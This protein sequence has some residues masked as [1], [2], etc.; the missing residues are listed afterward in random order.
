ME[1]IQSLCNQLVELAEKFNKNTSNFDKAKLIENELNKHKDVL[2]PFYN[3]IVAPM[4][5]MGEIIYDYEDTRRWFMRLEESY[6]AFYFFTF[7]RDME[8]QQDK[9]GRFVDHQYSNVL[10]KSI[11]FDPAHCLEQTISIFTDRLK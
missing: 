8:G 4:I 9:F 10:P 6:G 1:N 11:V 5:C 7:C 2:I 3:Q